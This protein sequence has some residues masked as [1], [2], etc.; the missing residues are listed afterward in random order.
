MDCPKCHQPVMVATAE[1]KCPFCGFAMV[2]LQ[3]R[4]MTLYVIS[5]GIFMSVLVYAGV[6]YMLEQQGFQPSLPSL[7]PVLPYALLAVS[8]ILIGVTTQL[9]GR[10][11]QR[12]TSPAQL[13]SLM[14]VR[15]ALAEAVAVFGL[16]LY[17]LSRS[18]EWFA[19]F[20][21][22]SFLAFLFLAGQMPAV[23]RKLGELVVKDEASG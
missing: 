22:L 14:I 20:V 1:G 4:L 15:L 7:P 23:A 3:R 11:V 17:M 13:Q 18:L 21:G 8:V 2:M 12:V 19:T 10:Q 6:V 9:L 5:F 16:V